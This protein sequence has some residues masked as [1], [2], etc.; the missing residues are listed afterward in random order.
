MNFEQGLHV[1][2]WARSRSG[3]AEG[4]EKPAEL[5][6]VIWGYNNKIWDTRALNYINNFVSKGVLCISK[7]KGAGE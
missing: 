4:T 1:R 2:K 5:L 6:A 7:L 3:V